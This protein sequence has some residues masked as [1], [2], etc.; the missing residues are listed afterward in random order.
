MKL[1][2][3]ERQFLKDKEI[4]E[5]WLFDAMRMPT[6]AECKRQMREAN[7]FVAVGLRR[8][9]EGHRLTNGRGKCLQC[10]PGSLKH[11]RPWIEPG[12]VYLA[13]SK[14]QRLVKVGNC[15]NLDARERTLNDHTYA[16]AADWLMKAYC[17]AKQPARLEHRIGAELEDWRM[18]VSYDRYGKPTYGREVFHCTYRRAKAAL[19]RLLE[20]DTLW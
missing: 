10:N 2:K 14:E 16:G 6:I 20:Q 12:L 17:E 8:C 13:E 9:D 1:T 19:Q 4:G 15:K 11:I 5:H 7:A 18:V 3:S